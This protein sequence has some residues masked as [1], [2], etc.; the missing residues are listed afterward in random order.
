ME[1]GRPL[2]SAGNFLGLPTSEDRGTLPPA[3]AELARPPRPQGATSGPFLPRTEFQ[4]S[5]P[6]DQ[7][8]TVTAEPPGTQARACDRPPNTPRRL[9][10]W[11]TWAH[12]EAQLP[13]WPALRPCFRRCFRTRN[14]AERGTAEHKLGGRERQNVQTQPLPTSSGWGGGDKD[15]GEADSQPDSDP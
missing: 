2:A 9:E 6:D 12:S 13:L 10:P 14:C 11:A 3:R 1:L 8:R 7:E 15:W 5:D 4:S